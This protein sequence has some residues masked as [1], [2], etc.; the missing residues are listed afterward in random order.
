MASVLALVKR[1]F[2]KRAEW[3]RYTQDLRGMHTTKEFLQ[4]I[5]QRD[6]KRFPLDRKEDVARRRREMEIVLDTLEIDLTGKAAL[7]IGPGYGDS[8]DVFHARGARDV[9]FIDYDPVYFTFNQLKGFATGYQANHLRKLGMFKAGRF[10]FVWSKAA[11]RDDLFLGP[12]GWLFPLSRWLRK[13]RRLLAPGGTAL[14]CPYW[15][16]VG[17]RRQIEDVASS[18][19]TKTMLECGF[20][21]LPFLE[22]HNYEPTVP[23]SY[24]LRMA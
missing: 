9:A 8:L 1:Q 13:V 21:M 12:L 23:V 4:Y 18:V 14:I 20:T 16:T 3:R 22:G 11:T 19:V 2:E 24:V 10:D 17:G 7:D 15:S 5:R 6:H